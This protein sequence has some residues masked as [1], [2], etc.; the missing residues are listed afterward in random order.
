MQ[1]KSLFLSFFIFFLWFIS[2]SF[3]SAGVIAHWKFDLP[4]GVNINDSVVTD[5]D[6]VNGFT[7]TKAGPRDIT[8]EAPAPST[9]GASILLDNGSTFNNN[10]SYLSAV[11][12]DIFT[13]LGSLTIEARVNPSEIKQSVIL[14][15]FANLNQATGV[16][17]NN[18]YWLELKADGGFGFHIG[19]SASN[20]I[21]VATNSNFAQIGQ[22]FTVRAVWD[23]TNISLFVDGV[24]QN[25]GTFNG[26]LDNTAGDIGIGAIVR[27]NDGSNTG[28]FFNG[29]I[30]EVVLGD[31]DV[32]ADFASI[33]EASS[34]LLLLLAFLPFF[35]VRK[36]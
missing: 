14:R 16:V 21:D 22:W 27:L 26:A 36:S 5:N 13:N 6:V 7:A 25:T 23:G 24:L 8:Y 34:F 17:N 31:G 10:G 11:D 20:F 29:F 18:G 4:P 1:K 35:I 19:N 3:S 12:N 32:P 28:Q 33:P 9:S 15:K 2:I 30:D